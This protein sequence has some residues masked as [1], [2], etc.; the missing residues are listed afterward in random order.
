VIATA[1]GPPPCNTGAN[2]L[3]NLSIRDDTGLRWDWYQATLK[4]S[5]DVLT[6]VNAITRALGETLLGGGRWVTCKGLYGYSQ[7]VE[8][9]GVLV[10]SVRVFWSAKDVHVQA[11]GE[12]AELVVDDLRRVWPQHLVSRADVAY[13]VVEPGSFERLYGR[14]YAIAR[15][16]R[17]GGK[18]STS[19]VGD[20]LD[21]E[22][23]R[24]FYA[25][26][27]SSRVRVRVYE[28]GHEQLAKDPGSKAPMDWTRT[29]WQLRPSTGQK[30]WMAQASKIEALGLSPFGADVA[31]DL[32]GVEV[33][34]VG[35]TLRFA[36][37]DPAYWMVRQYREVVLELLGLDPEDIRTRLVDLVEQTDMTDD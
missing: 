9:K 27:V 6:S 15:T 14:V 17:Q 16:V 4:G 25:G 21:A 24:T 3:E 11:T 30:A 20:W 26:G 34:P 1:I 33:V 22:D 19:T 5:S 32:L 2:K 8:L 31:E 12:A 28:K 23:G 29:E 18:V 37:Q 36:S 13:D 35:N 10:G 7:G